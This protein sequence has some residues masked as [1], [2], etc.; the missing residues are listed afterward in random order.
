M[1][2]NGGTKTR[3][4]AGVSIEHSRGKLL[5]GR[6]RSSV[7]VTKNTTTG[8]LDQYAGDILRVPSNDLTES[9]ASFL[10]KFLPALNIDDV[11][12]VAHQLLLESEVFLGT[13]TKRR[14]GVDFQQPGPQVFIHKHVVP[15]KLRRWCRLGCHRRESRG[16]VGVLLRDK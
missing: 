3:V 10:D 14:G 4:R 6:H 11:E 2:S 1:G 8:E 13:R 16:G 9:R 15:K 12:H 5:R 7:S